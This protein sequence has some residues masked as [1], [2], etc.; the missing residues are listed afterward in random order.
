MYRD[1]T[2]FR[3]FTYQ[4]LAC[5]RDISTWDKTRRTQEDHAAKQTESLWDCVVT[6]FRHSL[7]FAFCMAL[8]SDGRHD[9]ETSLRNV[10]I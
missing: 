6:T 8:H 3:P 7:Y 9:D 2:P 5:Q 4:A 1:L 10:Q